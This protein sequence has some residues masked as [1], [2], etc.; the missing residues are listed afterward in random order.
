MSENLSGPPKSEMNKYSGKFD[1]SKSF[2]PNI[3]LDSQAKTESVDLSSIDK[4]VNEHG[5]ANGDGKVDIL[6]VTTIQNSLAEKGKV[7][8]DMGDINGDGRVTVKDATILQKYLAGDTDYF[9]DPNSPISGKFNTPSSGGKINIFDENDDLIASFETPKE[10]KHEDNKGKKYKDIGTVSLK[11]N[12]IID[13]AVEMGPSDAGM[14]AAAFG[15]G[16][17]LFGP[18]PALIGGFATGV[19]ADEF[20]KSDTCDC[21]SGCCETDEY[22]IVSYR[23]DDSSKQRVKF[24]RKSDMSV[25]KEFTTNKLDHTNGLTTDGKYVYVANGKVA[26][27]ATKKTEDYEKNPEKYEKNTITRF[28]IDDPDLSNNNEPNLETIDYKIDGNQAMATSVSFDNQGR[29]VFVTA[30]GGTINISKPN[31]EVI[32]ASKVS[33]PE[34]SKLDT[35][36]ICVANDKIYVINTRFPDSKYVSQN[37]NW[38]LIDVYDID[39]KYEGT[40]KIEL[41]P[42]S[43]SNDSGEYYYE[44]ESMSFDGE[45]FTLYYQS[46]NWLE[47]RAAGNHNSP[48]HKIVTG[49]KLD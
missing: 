38:T 23:S 29:K 14:G 40:K 42:S 39:G 24:Y 32:R 49:V 36:D 19:G 16:N 1:F 45:S 15:I 7:A 12:K 27:D 9:E 10:V 13:V 35:Q 3:K 47:N 28:L 26:D 41:P 31:G 8:D 43:K 25:A 37:E 21:I 5:D 17:L 33:H 2:T 20:N 22:Y 46:P 44:L 6:D 48:P 34:E 4:Y 18:L 30:Q 11:D